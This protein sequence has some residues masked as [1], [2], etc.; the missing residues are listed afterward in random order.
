MSREVDDWIATT[1]DPQEP[2]VVV[3]SRIIFIVN[4]RTHELVAQVHGKT[5]DEARRR[6]NAILH[7]VTLVLGPE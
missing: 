2:G 7:G 3:E 6:A 5:P 4:C 1:T